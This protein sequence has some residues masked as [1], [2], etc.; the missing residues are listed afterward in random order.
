MAGT[1]ARP[2]DYFQLGASFKTLRRNT[3]IAAMSRAPMIR[4]AGP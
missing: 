4:K 3:G 2:T 1:E